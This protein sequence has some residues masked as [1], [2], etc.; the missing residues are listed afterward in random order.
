M[1]IA[2]F[3]PPGAGK[4]TQ[5]S[6]LEQEFGLKSISTGNLIRGAIRNE[7]QLGRIAES[8]VSSGDLVPDELVRDLANEAIADLDFR[9]FIL[10]GYPRTLQQAEWLT[11]FLTAHAAALHAVLS[12]DV[13]DDQIVQRLS[14]RRIH[15]DT[16]ESYHLDFRPPP[17]DVDPS[18]IIRRTDDEPDR[19][20]RRLETYRRDTKPLE[21]YFRKQGLLVEIPGTGTVDEVRQRISSALT[22]RMTPEPAH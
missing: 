19:V 16:S 22:A 21:E 2:L 17:P 1:R 14:R 7:T 8:Y 4:G 5:A 6:L 13:P 12:I 11:S 10:D 18:K 15:A 20:R 9:N 3:G